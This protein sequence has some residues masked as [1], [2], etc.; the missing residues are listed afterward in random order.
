MTFPL[1]RILITTD[2]V[3]G[4]FVFST[5]LAN[6]L[7]D[8]GLCVT[9]AT[10]GPA[11]NAAQRAAISECVDVEITDLEL[12]W[13]DSRGRDHAR[14]LDHLMTIAHRA[15]AELVHLNGFREANADWSMPVVVTAHSCVWSWWNACRGSGPTEPCWMAYRARVLEGLEAADAWVAPT[16]AFRDTVER[17]YSP[18][19]PGH[20][21]PNGLDIGAPPAIK[22]PVILASGRFWDEAKNLSALCPEG[23]R[24]RWPIEIAGD[25][26]IPNEALIDNSG[27]VFLGPLARQALLHRMR[28]AAIYVCPSLYE[29][30]GLAVLEAAASNCALLLADI[31]TLR[32]L[33]E[34][35][36]LFVDPRDP[37]QIAGELNR[38]CGDDALRARLQSAAR[39][40]S[41]RYSTGA[42]IAGYRRLYE[43]L[44]NPPHRVSPVR[45]ELR[46]SGARA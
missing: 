15:C 20:V 38:V 18:R 1:Q 30:F 6:A 7:A 42:M 11:P 29:P 41:R 10:L 8:A 46:L 35:A 32:E 28:Q 4:A 19:R 34:D 3:G 12:E 22:R 33:W 13:Q 24:A 40:R 45:S 39:E 31:P 26:G 16:A 27:C 44:L 37:E 5:I 9:L 25:L 2:A 17:L 23:A 21:I 36:A 14:A 43:T